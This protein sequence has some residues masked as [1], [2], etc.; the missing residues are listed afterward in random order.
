MLYKLN[1]LKQLYE[2]FCLCSILIHALQTQRTVSTVSTV[3]KYMS[4]SV[5]SCC[6]TAKNISKVTIV[7]SGSSHCIYC[8]VR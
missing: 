2:E 5:D 4:L 3:H 6:Q 8:N 7:Q 1:K